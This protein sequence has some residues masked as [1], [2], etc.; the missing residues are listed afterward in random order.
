MRLEGNGEVWPTSFVSKVW[1]VDQG[2]TTLNQQP[3]RD[4]EF[5]QQIKEACLVANA[6]QFL[7][8]LVLIRVEKRGKARILRCPR[9][10]EW[11]QWGR[12]EERGAQSG[13]FGSFF[14]ACG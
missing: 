2:K 4:I 8:N 11:S 14:A 1:L 6:A 12:P 9:L 3:M 5:R 10:A 7:A 13:D